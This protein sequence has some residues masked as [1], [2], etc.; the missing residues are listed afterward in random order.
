[1]IHEVLTGPKR[2]GWEAR[3]VVGVTLPSAASV[4]RA[5]GRKLDGIGGECDDLYDR[6]L[7]AGTGSALRAPSILHAG[8]TTNASTTTGRKHTRLP[9]PPAAGLCGL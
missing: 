7:A 2:S 8:W 5:T 3:I 6:D 9:S 4:F 1:M